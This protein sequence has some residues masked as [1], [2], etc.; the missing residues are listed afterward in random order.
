MNGCS[1][2]S[3]LFIAAGTLQSWVGRTIRLPY[4]IPTKNHA[5]YGVVLQLNDLSLLYQQFEM[6]SIEFID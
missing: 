4:S 3:P 6:G 1:P 5:V 2:Q